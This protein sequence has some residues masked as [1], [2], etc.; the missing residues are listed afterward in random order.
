MIASRNNAAFVVL[1]GVLLGAASASMGQMAVYPE[2]DVVA[3]HA[4]AAIAR[5]KLGPATSAVP[6]LSRRSTPD[7][8]IVGPDSL[9]LDIALPLS[10]R[11]G[12]EPNDTFADATDTGLVTDGTVIVLGA[13]LGNGD[14]P[15]HDVDIYRLEVAAGAVLPK[16][17][18]ARLEGEPDQLDG[19]LRLYD[20]VGYSIASNDDYAYPDL[21][22]QCATYC[23]EPGVYYV[24]VLASGARPASNPTEGFYDLWITVEQAAAP[25]EALEPNDTFADATDTGGGP[26]QALGRFIGDGAHGRSDVDVYRVALTGPAVV[27]ARADVDHL[28]S[29]LDPLLSLRSS[30]GTYAVNDNAD[31]DTRDARIEAALLEAGDYYVVVAGAGNYLPVFDPLYLGIGEVGYYD[32]TID[33]TPLTDAGGPFEPNDSILQATPVVVTPPGPTQLSGYVGDGPY[34]D[35]RGDFDYYEIQADP[36]DTL[37]VKVHGA[38]G[39]LDPVVVVFDYLGRPVAR[40]DNEPGSTNS[41][42]SV[43]AQSPG[44]GDPSWLYVMVLGTRQPRPIDPL[45]P[46]PSYQDQQARPARHVVSDADPSTG[47]YDLFFYLEPGVAGDCCIVHDTPGCADEEIEACVCAFDSYCCTYQWDEY[48]VFLVTYFGCGECFGSGAAIDTVPNFDAQPPAGAGTSDRL[49]ATRLD[50]APQSLIELDS[51]NGGVLAE[52]DLPEGWAT[53]GQGLALLDDTLFFMG[54]GRFPKL[55][56]LDP[57]TAAVLQYTYLWSG[58]GY[59]GDLAVNN[60]HLFLTDVFDQALHEIDP[61]ALQAVQTIDVGVLNGIAL[62]GAMASLGGP[63]RLYLADAF[64]QGGIHAVDPATGLA[65]ATLSAGVPCPCNADFD[66]DGDVDADDQ[67]FF[68]NC[69]AADGS[70]PHGCRPADLNCDQ[71]YDVADQAILDCQHNG[72]GNPPNPDCCTDG[73][74]FVPIRATALG[75][76][77][78]DSLFVN[79]WNRH[80]I[81]VYDRNGV[82]LDSWPGGP[83]GAIGGQP[84]HVVGILEVRSC[85]DHAGTVW[86]LPL[87]PDSNTEPRLPGVSELAVELTHDVGS[88]GAIGV[89]VACTPAGPYAGTITTSLGAGPAGLH[90][91]VTIGLD[92][93]LSDENCC[94]VTL[95]GDVEA[96]FQIRILAGDVNFSGRVN[97]TD[98]NLVKGEMDDPFGANNFFC[99]VDATGAINA[100]D[101]NLVKGWIDALSPDCP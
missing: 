4:D 91:T 88:N 86:C 82:I 95:T 13:Y 75:G 57:D 59:Y 78:T 76:T 51:I 93:P 79:D 36:G 23:L 99:D 2:P 74:P 7:G 49:F 43:E 85:L 32:L 28:N 30:V 48:C 34:A 25:D 46:F 72:A 71:V 68:D 14:W 73:L 50:F 21:D 53:A 47:P 83:Y 1:L 90:G 29:T 69:D 15:E 63:D 81:D 54:S 45:V 19:R 44:Y 42:V 26:Y 38:G 11:T 60:G 20:A 8:V 17:L 97:A 100:T 55:Y 40:N 101:K 58:S 84:R 61:V 89:A 24:S 66:G 18:T 92:P 65:N 77:G 16:V 62:S 41:V 5:D 35:A 3:G 9:D 70:V 12:L 94:T 33:V 10:E 52:H 27:E 39:A 6:P 64:D 96:S 67:A 56:W 37:L 80:S 31:L 87:T 22:P 98:K